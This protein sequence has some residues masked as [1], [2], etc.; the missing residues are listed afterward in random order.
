VL[1]DLFSIFY[2]II[3]HSF[4]LD[5]IAQASFFHF[6]IFRSFLID[7]QFN[8]QISVYLS[9]NISFAGLNNHV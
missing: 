7:N 6:K 4:F 9:S 3:A 8:R 5:M 2:P 1:F